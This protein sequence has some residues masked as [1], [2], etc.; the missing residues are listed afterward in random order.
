[1]I[2]FL[3]EK[4]LR[5]N[6]DYSTITASCPTI[7]KYPDPNVNIREHS[8][9]SW[10][11]VPEYNTLQKFQ[12]AVLAEA[13]KDYVCIDMCKQA[14]EYYGIDPFLDSCGNNNLSKE[15]METIVKK[16]FREW[17]HPMI[18]NIGASPGIRPQIFYYQYLENWDQCQFIDVK[19]QIAIM[20]LYS[21][22]GLMDRSAR[23]QVRICHNITEIARAIIGEITTVTS[24]RLDKIFALELC[25]SENF[26]EEQRILI[27]T[28][29]RSFGPTLEIAFRN[30]GAK[31]GFSFTDYIKYFFPD[32]LQP[33]MK[34]NT[35]E[36]QWFLFEEF[37]RKL[38]PDYEGTSTYHPSPETKTIIDSCNTNWD[39][40]P[41]PMKG[42]ILINEF[43]RFG[44]Q[45]EGKKLSM[46]ICDPKAIGNFLNIPYQIVE[47]APIKNFPKIVFKGDARSLTWSW[48][49]DEYY[50]T[51]ITYRHF[52]M[53]LWGGP[54]GHGTGNVAFVDKLLGRY[55]SNAS[56]VLSGLFAFWR[57]YYDK[58]ISVVHTLAE[59][60][61]SSLFTSNL[62]SIKE[63]EFNYDNLPEV[64]STIDAF[65]L[66]CNVASLREN[67]FFDPILLMWMIRKRYYCLE[68]CAYNHQKAFDDLQ[69]RIDILRSEL[70][71]QE[72]FVPLWTKDL[73]YRTGFKVRSFSFYASH[74]RSDLSR[75][76]LLEAQENDALSLSIAIEKLSEGSVKISE[77]YKSLKDTQNEA[78]KIL[79]DLY[80]NLAGH[81]NTITLDK[82][83]VVNGQIIDQ[84]KT[85]L[86]TEAFT[87][88]DAVLSKPDEMGNFTLTGFSPFM[89]F[90]QLKINVDFFVS[91][92][93]TDDKNEVLQCLIKPDTIKVNL[94]NLAS[95]FP[96]LPGYIDYSP[97]KIGKGFQKSFLTF[98]DFANPILCFSSYDFSLDSCSYKG[99][100][101]LSGETIQT[102][103]NYT[104]NITTD[105]D[106]WNT[107]K[108][109]A[110]DL[111]TLDIFGCIA[112]KDDGV[113][114]EVGHRFEGSF[115][116]S[117]ALP[118]KLTKII[119]RS[120]LSAGSLMSPGFSILCEINSINP[121]LELEMDIGISRKWIGISG[122]FQDGRVL[123]LAEIADKLGMEGLL[124]SNFLPQGSVE[125]DFG[126]IGL[127]DFNLQM[128]IAPA[129]VESLGFTISAE[130]PWVIIDNKVTVQP[131]FS[132]EIQN[133][134]DK[135]NRS[136]SLEIMGKWELGK[137]DFYVLA[138]PLS[139]DVSAIM[140]E[141]QTL[142]V[143][144]L[145]GSLI[146]G[147]TLPKIEL[148]KMEFIANYL[149]KTY[150][151]NL[152]AAT[153]LDFDLVICKL[154]IFDV[155]FSCY[156][157]GS[158]LQDLTLGGTFSLAG[159]CFNVEGTYN[160]TS[161]WTISGGI[162]VDT[163]IHF[164]EIFNSL[165]SDLNIQANVPDLIP[166]KYLSI[167]I[168]SMYINYQSQEK[169]LTTFVDLI[170]P[171]EITDAFKIDEVAIQL[172][173]DS[174]GLQDGFVK[175]NL[176]IVSIDIIL[177]LEKNESEWFFSGATPP[178]Q[179]IPVGEL[180]EDLFKKFGC[181]VEIPNC[182]SGFVIENINISYKPDSQNMEFKFSCEGIVPIEEKKNL[183]INLDITLIKTG[184]DYAFSLDGNFKIGDITFIIDFELSKGLEYL[185]ATFDPQ[186]ECTVNLGE[187]IS[188]IW[189]DAEE[190]IP[191]RLEI[192]LK[193]V[194]FVL[195]QEKEEIDTS[196][197]KLLFGVDIGSKFD[198]S[199]VEV[200]GTLF[201][202]DTDIGID[203]LQAL[204]V[205]K[206]V[207]DTLLKSINDTLSNLQKPS[208]KNL[209]EK[210]VDEY[211]F[212]LIE[213]KAEA[214]FKILPEKLD[215]PGLYITSIF[216]F[217]GYKSQIELP[218]VKK[219]SV[220]HKKQE[221]IN[222]LVLVAVS[223]AASEAS[224][225]HWC[226][227]NKTI[228]PIQLRRIGIM[229][230]G[231]HTKFE[232][233]I[234]LVTASLEIDLLDLW[235]G[236]DISNPFGE[237]PSFGIHGLDVAYSQPPT[238]FNGGLLYIE[239]PME[240]Y[241][242]EI[243]GQLIVKYNQYGFFADASYAQPTQK[244]MSSFF[245]F[246]MVSAPIGGPPYLYI[247]GLAG[248]FGFNRTLLV[249]QASQLNEFPL[250]Q[251]VLGTG[252]LN[253]GMKADE[254]LQKMDTYVP[255]KEND[256]WL[257]AGVAVGS[258]QIIN[259]YVMVAGVFGT[260]FDF[261]IIGVATADVPTG[262]SP[263]L[264]AHL[265]LALVGNINPMKGS[266]EITGAITSN[267]YLFVPECKLTGG[268][269]IC[270]WLDRGDFVV[271]VGGYSTAFKKPDHYP[272]L[273]RL[274]IN[275]QISSNLSLKGGAY[276]AYTPSCAMA[277]G[278]LD[279][280]F[281]LGEIKAWLTAHADLIMEWLP[282]HYD[283]SIGVN[284][285]VSV[286]IKVWFVHKTFNLEVGADLHMWGPKFSGEATIH[287][288]IISFTISFGENRNKKPPKLDWDTFYKSLLSNG[289]EQSK[290]LTD[291]GPL[292][293]NVL[294]INIK[295]GL[296]NG[297]SYSDGKKDYWVVSPD[298]FII[299]THSSIPSSNVQLKTDNENHL[300]DL[301]DFNTSV[302]IRP[303][304]IS[305]LN[306]EHVVSIFNKHANG[307]WAQIDLSHIACSVY[308][309]NLP[310]AVWSGEELSRPSSGTL[311]F[312]VGIVI[313]SVDAS[314][315][316]L[317]VVSTEVFM[318]EPLPLQFSWG[319]LVQPTNPAYT[320][321]P[322]EKLKSSIMSGSVVTLRNDI[323]NS[324]KNNGFSVTESIDL[325]SYDTSAEN[326]LRAEPKLFKLGAEEQK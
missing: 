175:L 119:I 282:F 62:S 248:G 230:D 242:W 134:F 50:L 8:L 78:S 87:I 30:Q 139:G 67:K 115:N 287:L 173:F 263:E 186:N 167:E 225:V 7:Q 235:I 43:R 165:I 219:T 106:F 174:Q 36:P 214:S 35:F 183:D 220:I 68:N 141:N 59:T 271:S 185:V 93:Q 53:Q 258:C 217:S 156:Y 111:E 128:T 321:K 272:T 229:L 16:I 113:T 18:G 192:K 304:G 178:D 99:E 83:S 247:S 42:A 311:N 182:I 236:I 11:E 291:S 197:M 303:M 54:S 294:N 48:N 96:D 216:N 150:Y 177:T 76:L 5:T 222:E 123:T 319:N 245:A 205:T 88:S 72:F 118:V 204:I 210:L 256:Y 163:T 243:N 201:Q 193:D 301:K 172:H 158:K 26:K 133:P 98:I 25:L 24:R 140:K 260:D 279:L 278:E 309:E 92:D 34:V 17:A 265:E 268:F 198:L 13:K 127:K 323:L 187:T 55:L 168:S 277:G 110:Q 29:L 20:T 317:P 157:D 23:D 61:E 194:F 297:I 306:T 200:L 77:G 75:A 240:G 132:V 251:G 244:R 281:S 269:A 86:N 209:P 21:D 169:S 215:N 125:E 73:S 95:D 104:A 138:L 239:N 142:D 137:T 154:S 52:L 262:N 89:K 122:F 159:I 90:G 149:N 322:I 108:Q 109:I 286:T 84:W 288:W 275:W 188:N 257:A 241:S 63:I 143:S 15:T 33:C 206:P 37:I 130:K 161:L 38:V 308:C 69:K 218:I 49:R 116:I 292:T 46:C 221:K 313:S 91:Y 207:S 195:A 58:R 146:P 224:N 103:I 64:T 81:G 212:V 274:G 70:E 284:V 6:N 45:V 131:F 164:K 151:V 249:P 307:N 135:N 299:L 293:S 234:S 22:L 324:L 94:W 152:S 226:S 223:D 228:G 71:M 254:A 65:D 191:E 9:I 105:H 208:S 129:N 259:A 295:E 246:L 60:M 176:T 199:E 124:L 19:T 280:N 27:K 255:P 136:T 237:L 310:E 162:P 155:G 28:L 51:T 148:E 112:S 14:L 101:Q 100:M 300:F 3:I 202:K 290:V 147:V 312:P 266:I 298:K 180:I 57:L 160:E 47:A 82:N 44:T 166:E 190:V 66:V 211:D 121:A 79:S 117:E 97:D 227:I 10:N 32:S 39:T 85:L 31:A 270:I 238:V 114:L 40:M 41:D 107:V 314:Y 231:N 316:E 296:V 326:I 233:D 250:V 203:D 273:S 126:T 1:M 252:N 144:A 181:K 320:E 253:S 267:S 179:K 315:Y 171:I 2:F 184:T 102:G 170:N 283:V 12:D 189:A 318:F 264:I 153:S 325:K 80:I 289:N 302:G 305:S 276:C 261:T 232:I 4:E 120:G 196:G 145:V 56:I 74:S 213:D 285:G